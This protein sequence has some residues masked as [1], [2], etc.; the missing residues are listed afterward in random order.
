MFQ[1]SLKLLFLILTAG[2][3]ISQ[4]SGEWL[5]ADEKCSE[6]IGK[7]T[8][9]KPYKHGDDKSKIKVS[10]GD[11]LEIIRRP[12][13]PGGQHYWVKSLLNQKEGLLHQDFF[14]PRTI[15]VKDEDLIPVVLPIDSPGP[16]ADIK[17]SAPTQVIDGT[18]LYGVNEDAPAY[19]HQPTVDNRSQNSETTFPATKPPSDAPADASSN[20]TSTRDEGNMNTL[21]EPSLQ[22]NGEE[23]GISSTPASSI[24]SSTPTPDVEI[25]KVSDAS[26][27]SDTPQSPPIGEEQ[28]KFP[29]NAVEKPLDGVNIE[30]GGPKAE[31]PSGGTIFGNLLSFMVDDSGEEPPDEV[32]ERLAPAGVD[33]GSLVA[34]LGKTKETK[35]TLVATDVQKD[36]TIDEVTVE[37][38]ESAE[39]GQDAVNLADPVTLESIVKTP[40]KRSSPL[41]D[42][43][44]PPASNAQKNSPV[45]AFNG[46]STLDSTAVNDGPARGMIESNETTYSEEKM[47][48]SVSN[49][50]EEIPSSKPMPSPAAEQVGDSSA[51]K[52]DEPPQNDVKTPQNV[53]TGANLIDSSALQAGAS[54]SSEELPSSN[55]ISSPAAD[56]VVDSSTAKPA[57]LPQNNVKTPQVT[58][59]D[60]SPSSIDSS[61]LQ[62]GTSNG[63]VEVSSSK[64]TSTPVAKQLDDSSAAKPAELLQNN[65]ESSRNKL[66]NADSNSTHP[67]TDPNPQGILQ[68]KSTSSPAAEKIGESSPAKPA[69]LPQNIAESSQASIAGETNSSSDDSAKQPIAKAEPPFKYPMA[70]NYV[71]EAS[72]MISPESDEAK[73]VGRKVPSIDE[74]SPA[75]DASISPEKIIAPA[76]SSDSNPGNRHFDSTS[77]P[78]ISHEPKQSPV[79]QDSSQASDPG[80]ARTESTDNLETFPAGLDQDSAVPSS[81]SAV[82][83]SDPTMPSSNSEVPSSDSA[84]PSQPSNFDTPPTQPDLVE[85]QPWYS[86][87]LNLYSNLQHTFSS[88]SP[89]EDDVAAPEY[90]ASEEPA[91]EEPIRSYG[92]QPNCDIVKEDADDWSNFFYGLS[93]Q[94]IFVLALTTLTVLTF[95]LGLYYLENHRRDVELVKKYNDL[96]GKLFIEQ[97]EKEMLTQQLATAN[98]T[99][100]QISFDSTR[101]DEEIS[102]LKTLV[103]KYKGEKN[104]AEAKEKET[105]KKHLMVEKNYNELRKILSQN[106]QKGERT[107]LIADIQNLKDSITANNIEIASLKEQLIEKKEE[108]KVL[109]GKI[110]QHIE[111]QKQLEKTLE[112][113]ISSNHD[114]AQK[115]QDSIAKLEKSIE[116]STAARAKLE[117]ECTQ[118]KK[119]KETIC[120]EKEILESSLQK[121]QRLQPSQ[122]LDEWL[123]AK[124]VRVALLACEKRIDEF[125]E[126]EESLVKEKSTLEDKLRIMQNDIEQLNENYEKAEKEKVEAFTRLQVLSDYFKEKETQLQE[127]L[128]TKEAF[129]VQ[130][131]SEDKT[132]YEQMRALRE[133]NASFKKQNENL[134]HEILEQEASFKKLITSAEEKAHEN[135][136]ALRHNERRLKETQVE[137]AQ[138]RARLTA[139][140]AP[141][142]SA[143]EMNGDGANGVTSQFGPTT[144]PPPPFMMFHPQPG[145]FV[146]PPPLVPLPPSPSSR[147]S[148]PP[149][150]GRISSPPPLRRIASPPPMVGDFT[151]PPPLVPYPMF[152]PPSASPPLPH[153][154]QKPQ[155][156]MDGMHHRTQTDSQSSNHSSD[157][158]PDKPR[159][160]KR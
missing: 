12:R 98:D 28:S 59:S 47:T 108:I 19:L 120:I 39:I 7:A 31:K 112:N 147:L 119:E 107:A 29:A 55:S 86:S 33:G 72:T 103:E 81:D 70:P 149:P 5:C 148:R 82:P 156:L 76:G 64:P 87:I 104:S 73:R 155:P 118:L 25:P 115:Y 42:T 26:T 90:R 69:E 85:E 127:E 114:A 129:W 16:N 58:S 142:N 150:L 99:M 20:D 123:D 38:V 22:K 145:E 93:P 23:L 6:P 124:E 146:P 84:F 9:L 96:A 50:S 65:V 14:L 30:D 95:S 13:S 106:K 10:I 130:K 137:A 43:S 143:L 48:Y 44:S 53:S 40:K 89:A 117:N 41:E 32:M 66:L 153:V 133:E 100:T 135:W 80:I 11:K 113:T 17:P 94:H 83:S 139:L 4:Q 128:G 51:A 111:S 152:M 77:G 57:E 97:K 122:S 8:V 62:A 151:P 121:Y 60:T 63:S 74:T 34:D 37:S 18:T 56:K 15:L 71:P 101:Y 68:S 67:A 24:S 116:E 36:P 125:K 144:S 27:V 159:R 131:Q 52:S 134:K 157:S 126:K 61:A 141:D 140:E 21:T 102:Q 92:D 136:V 132:I 91:K 46:S 154:I 49:S 105:M 138:L 88:S 35:D 158:T 79:E 109:N 2:P 75:V 160:S 3:C 110:A 1:L 54:N 45:D 78:E